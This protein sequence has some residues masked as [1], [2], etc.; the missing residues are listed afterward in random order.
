MA[1][2]LGGEAEALPE[3]ASSPTTSESA[4]SRETMT[5]FLYRNYFPLHKGV[6]APSHGLGLH[7]MWS[8]RLHPRRDVLSSGGYLDIAFWST[9]ASCR[10]L[11]SRNSTLRL[12]EKMTV[13]LQ[14]KVGS[15]SPSD[16][17]ARVVI[18]W[19]PYRGW[20]TMSPLTS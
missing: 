3:A 1:L 4:E 18:T 15:H 7:F 11:F 9:R 13:L 8:G 6:L 5:A 19:K 2:F 16:P 17:F 10:A 12:Q 20:L 14:V